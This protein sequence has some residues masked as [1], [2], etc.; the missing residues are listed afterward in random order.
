MAN[1][2]ELSFSG[3]E[4][5]EECLRA[6]ESNANLEQLVIWGG[7]LTNDRFAP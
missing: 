4:I 1:E 2:K 6:L 5:T 7:P 3:D